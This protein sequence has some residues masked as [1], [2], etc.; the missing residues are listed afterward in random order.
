M[1]P[2]SEVTVRNWFMQTGSLRDSSDRITFV[3]A[4]SIGVTVMPAREIK[5]SVVGIDVVQFR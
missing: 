1:T 2:G 4:D 3:P 5:K